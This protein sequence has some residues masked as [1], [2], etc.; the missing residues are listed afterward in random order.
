MKAVPVRI[1]QTVGPVACAINE[2]THVM[3]HIPSRTYP[4]VF[5]VILK[6]SRDK[7]G[8]W[9]WNG[10]TDKPTLRPSVL[11][12]NHDTTF[13]CHSW[14]NDGQAKFL[15]DCTHKMVNQTVDLLDVT[16]PSYRSPNAL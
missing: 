14:V 2:C 12:Q 6:G 15:S 11:T 10:D 9:T 4:E 1:V 13:R 3:I 8:C 5:P 16:P 7:T